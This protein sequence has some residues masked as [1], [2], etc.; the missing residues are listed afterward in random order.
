MNILFLSISPGVK[1]GP[2]FSSY[3]ETSKGVHK[4]SSEAVRCAGPKVDLVSL[5]FSCPRP[6][7]SSTHLNTCKCEIVAL[8]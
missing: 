2:G 6:K 4:L 3:R 5:H 8:F 1:V 7:A